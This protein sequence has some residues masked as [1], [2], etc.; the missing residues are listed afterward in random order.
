MLDL[1]NY[2][3]RL[4]PFAEIDYAVLLGDVILIPVLDEGQGSE[5]DTCRYIIITI[6]V[7]RESIENG[8]QYVPRKGTQGG[9]T[10]ASLARYSVKFLFESIVFS[11]SSNIAIIFAFTPSQVLFSRRIGGVLRPAIRAAMLEKL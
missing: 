2:L 7:C 10:V 6:S 4:L 11:K 5:V 9:L 8:A 3:R 1:S